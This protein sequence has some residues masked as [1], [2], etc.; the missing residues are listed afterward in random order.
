MHAILAAQIDRAGK[1]AFLV[2]EVGTRHLN[3]RRSRG[4]VGAGT[5]ELDHLGAAVA[6]ALDDGVQP[7]LRDELADRNAV[8]GAVAEHGDHGVAM[9]AEHHGAHVLDGHP[10]L[11]RQEELKT[12]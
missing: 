5:H 9:T 6:R 10:C 8:D 1:Q 11:T 4:V 7:V 3:G 2:V 12:R